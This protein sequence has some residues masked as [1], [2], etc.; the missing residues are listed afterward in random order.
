M[1]DE[2]DWM[3][4]EAAVDEFQILLSNSPGVTE[5][6][7]ESSVTIADFRACFNAESSCTRQPVDRH[8]WCSPQAHR[9]CS[10]KDIQRQRLAAEG[11]SRWSGVAIEWELGGPQRLSRLLEGKKNS[12]C[13]ESN[14]HALV[15][16]P[17]T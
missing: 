11:G 13:R 7:R 4:Y 9:S 14:H 3:W 12:P 6:N 5:E 15:V 16:H 17:I 8:A 10:C 2:L 1:T